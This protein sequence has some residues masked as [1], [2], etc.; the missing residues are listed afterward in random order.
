[1][2]FSNP[3]PVAVAVVPYKNGLLGIRRGIEPKKGQVAF[4]GGYINSGETFHQALSRELLEET[5]I[6]ISEDAWDVFHIGDSL[7][8]NRILI[9][10]ICKGVDQA[11]LK[12]KSDETQ[13]VLVIDPAT[14]LAFPLHDDVK[15]KFFAS[16]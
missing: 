4:P 14:S 7:Q 1:M 3:V 12:F 6:S 5:G 2:T 10:G 16:T 11:N 15:R 13:E 8:S 9:F